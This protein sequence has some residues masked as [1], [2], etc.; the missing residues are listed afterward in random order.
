MTINQAVVG[1]F[2]GF[3]LRVIAIGAEREL[4]RFLLHLK[5]R[6]FNRF[7]VSIKGDDVDPTSPIEPCGYTASVRSSQAG[8][9][10]SAL[11]GPKR[12]PMECE[13]PMRVCGRFLVYYSDQ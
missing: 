10:D 9:V 3:I 5:N 7:R 2:D 4:G 12:G 8:R 13:Q 6:R 1:G 11:V